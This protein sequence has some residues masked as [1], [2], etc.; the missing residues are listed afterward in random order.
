M[1]QIQNEAKYLQG[2]S[3]EETRNFVKKLDGNVLTGNGIS[4]HK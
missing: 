4:L 2:Q 1:L 3:T